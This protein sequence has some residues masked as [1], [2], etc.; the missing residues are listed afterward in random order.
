MRRSVLAT[1]VSVL[2]VLGGCGSDSDVGDDPGAAP[3]ASG[4]PADQVQVVAATDVYADIVRTIGGDLV[5]VQ[6]LLSSDSGADPHS[7]EATARDQL[8][9][10][11]ADLVMANGGHYDEFLTRALDAAGGERTV[12][13]AV[14]EANHEDEGEAVAAGS[15]A[16]HDH[17][18]DSNEH[19]WYDLKAM[20]VLATGIAGALAALRPADSAGFTARA[21]AFQT[22]LS[23][24]IDRQAAIREKHG[25]LA[26]AVTEPLPLFLLNDCGLVDK[27]PAGFS[28]AI[29]E[30][31]D[32]PVRTL[33]ETLDLFADHAVEVLVYNSQTTGPQTERVQD[34]A[35]DADIPV[36][37]M[38]ETLPAGQD[39]LSWMRAN[40]D[41]LEG[42]LEEGPA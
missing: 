39:Y 7:Y 42:A 33:Q 13:T 21:G 20:N 37:P 40:L 4:T 27:T 30:G 26:V 12:L 10:K 18:E 25:G 19:V 14:T 6:A 32:V 9:V 17:G 15:P 3:T 28:E 38:S 31:T 35:E 11:E 24:L 36:V 29:E 2:L 16:P 41:A 34:A 22:E 5:D 1:G 8:A 23:D